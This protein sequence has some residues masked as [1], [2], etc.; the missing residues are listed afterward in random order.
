MELSQ[1]ITLFHGLNSYVRIFLLVILVT[2]DYGNR[3]VRTASC[4][5]EASNA[6]LLVYNMSLLIIPHLQNLLGAESNADPATFAPL[7]EDM[8]CWLGALILF[9]AI[10]DG[11]WRI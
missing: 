1:V 2:L 4:T 5:Q 7:R 6:V 11:Y 8:N 3:K 9:L 10:I